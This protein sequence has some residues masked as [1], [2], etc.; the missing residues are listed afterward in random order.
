MLSLPS[1]L[2]LF[3]PILTPALLLSVYA[4]TATLG[5]LPLMT[6]SLYAACTVSALPFCTATATDAITPLAMLS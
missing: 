2:S 6:A 5:C 3:A 1:S 4:W